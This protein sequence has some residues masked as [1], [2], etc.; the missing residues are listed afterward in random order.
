VYWF[1]GTHMA[2]LVAVQPWFGEVGMQL[3][4]LL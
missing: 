2:V 4:L 3:L 1:Y